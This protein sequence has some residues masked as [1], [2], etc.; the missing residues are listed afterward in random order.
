[1]STIEKAIEKLKTKP[2]DFTYDE[3]KRILNYLGFI[4]DNKGKTSGSRVGF[5][6]KQL[7]REI[8]LHKPHPGNILKEY[9][10][11]DTLKNLIEWRIL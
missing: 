9:Q 1:M 3:M 6:N 2:K 8:K 5:L 10:I 11:K 7:N 4:E